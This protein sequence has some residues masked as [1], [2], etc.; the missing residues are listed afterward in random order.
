[1][2]DND[3][4]DAAEAE[5]LGDL[6]AAGQPA[7]AHYREAQSLL[8]PA[9]AVW[10][11]RAAYDQRMEA[12]ERIQQKIYALEVQT[13]PLTVW[14]FSPGLVVRV[15]QSFRDYDGQEIHAG[16]VLHFLG[17]TYFPYDS[18]HTLTFQEKVI[19]LA[20][21][22]DEH[23]LIIANAGNAWFQPQN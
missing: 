6:A 19:R 20:G 17:S 9:G 18:G 16:E 1:M 22:V 12:F 3:L 13:E 15:C 14:D 2:T 23:E 4:N 7:A 5:R 8:L 10:T 21:V 11:D